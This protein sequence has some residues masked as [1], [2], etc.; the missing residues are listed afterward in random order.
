MSEPM[1]SRNA[2]LGCDDN[3]TET[4][5]VPQWGGSVRVK[6]LTA[7][8]RDRIEAHIIGKGG[9]AKLENLRARMAVASVID[10][11]GD[12]MFT[13][14]D[15]AALASK[16]AAALDKVF[17]AAQRLSAMSDEDVEELTGE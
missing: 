2:I 16:S 12:P 3:T 15:I 13:E 4:V 17:T 9:K 11:A 8:E 6:S 7:K 14:E 10:D 5:H 1:L